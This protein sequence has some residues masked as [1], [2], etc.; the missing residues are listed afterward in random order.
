MTIIGSIAIKTKS[1]DYSEIVISAIVADLI[2]NKV[3]IVIDYKN[4]KTK[5]L[6]KKIYDFSKNKKGEI[7]EVPDKTISTYNF[8]INTNN[9]I[10]SLFK[11]E[12]NISI[13]RNLTNLIKNDSDYKWIIESYI[14]SMNAK[15]LLMEAQPVID[16]AFSDI[17]FSININFFQSINDE[18]HV[19]H[20]NFELNSTRT[21]PNISVYIDEAEINK[22]PTS[23]EKFKNQYPFIHGTAS[24]ESLIDLFIYQ[25]IPLYGDKYS[26]VKNNHS[27]RNRLIYAMSL[28]QKALKSKHYDLYKN[29][30]SDPLNEQMMKNFNNIMDKRPELIDPLLHESIN[31]AFNAELITIDKFLGIN[32]ETDKTESMTPD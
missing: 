12:S 29:V 21:N 7:L 28:Y 19:N 2:I 20:G 1:K 14:K 15:N 24:P 26:I 3:P 27:H 10:S 8:T 32:I 22:I 11:R 17:T 13:I 31:T 5:N 18:K 30:K 23:N 16:N 9:S 25:I 4:V 6:T